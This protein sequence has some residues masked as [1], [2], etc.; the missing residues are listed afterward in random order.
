MGYYTLFR[1]KYSHKQEKI[2]KFTRRLKKTNKDFFWY[3]KGDEYISWHDH[4]KDILTISKEFP[5][6]LISVYGFGEDGNDKW[7]QYFKNGQQTIKFDAL[8]IINYNKLQQALFA[9]VTEFKTDI[10]I[11]YKKFNEKLL[12]D[13]N[14]GPNTDQKSQYI[15]P[16]PE[17]YFSDSE[18]ESD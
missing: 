9:D 15:S 2:K 14:V 10:R 6:V 3:D 16:C 5:S 11:K 7:V 12:F 8:V 4:E 1:F 18:A 13:A 17:N